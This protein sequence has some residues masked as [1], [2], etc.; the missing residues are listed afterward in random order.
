MAVVFIIYGYCCH[1]VAICGAT[2]TGTFA[3]PL[4]LHHP[5]MFRLAMSTIPSSCRWDTAWWNGERPFAWA[6][7]MRKK[8]RGTCVLGST[9]LIR[10]STFWHFEA[11]TEWPIFCRRHFRV[12]F[13][14]RKSLYFDFT[15][16]YMRRLISCVKI[17][18]SPHTY[19]YDNLW[20]CL[21]SKSEFSTASIWTCH[22]RTDAE[23]ISTRIWHF[24]ASLCGGQ[25]WPYG[26]L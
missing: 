3:F 11:T 17:N 22:N 8:A 24:V 10:H 1:L 19:I 14:E 9:R 4:T 7:S 5:S 6:W 25:L 23:P 18:S 15:D 2:S 20:Q 13:L 12:N 26:I 21:Q 16:A